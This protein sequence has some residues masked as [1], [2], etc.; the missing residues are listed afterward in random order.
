VFDVAG[1][2]RKNSATL[3]QWVCVY[4]SAEKKKQLCVPEDFA[5]GFYVTSNEGQ[6]VYKCTD[7]YNPKA[8]VS[9]DWSY[10]TLNISWP[11]L[12]HDLV[13]TSEKD[14]AGLS[15]ADFLK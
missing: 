9:I 8:E 14:S 15:V 4:L 2:I 6:F 5:R 3:G 10:A 12:D 1:D 7:Y 11:I 13:I